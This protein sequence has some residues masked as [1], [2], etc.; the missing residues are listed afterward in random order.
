[1]QETARA[2]LRACNSP[3]SLSPPLSLPPPPCPRPL[4][5]QTHP[6]SPHGQCSP[7]SAGWPCVIATQSVHGL[8]AGF[9]GGALCGPSSDRGWGGVWTDEHL[10]HP[11]WSARNHHRHGPRLDTKAARGRLFLLLHLSMCPARDGT[12]NR[13]S[14]VF[15]VSRPLGLAVTCIGAC[16]SLAVFRFFI[17]EMS[18][19]VIRQTTTWVAD[20]FSLLRV[21]AF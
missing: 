11:S 4:L 17:R 10:Y 19:P 9:S 2:A 3:Y 14:S 21:P 13:I 18:C 1:M 8:Q 5:C 12:R 16:I 15:A 7:R 20:V 6:R